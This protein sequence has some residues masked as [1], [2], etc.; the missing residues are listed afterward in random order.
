MN[1]KIARSHL[2]ENSQNSDRNVFKLFQLNFTCFQNLKVVKRTVRASHVAR[3]SRGAC[4]ARG[5]RVTR[6]ALA[7]SSAYVALNLTSWRWKFHEQAECGPKSEKVLISS[8]GCTELVN[9]VS[10]WKLYLDKAT[11]SP[12]NLHN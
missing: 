3:A 6:G 7:A 12:P 9:R 5:A 1:L 4:A 2:A 10:H 11:K 8:F